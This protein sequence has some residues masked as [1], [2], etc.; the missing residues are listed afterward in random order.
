MATFNA[1]EEMKRAF[2][3]RNNFHK[4]YQE[5]F[6]K[7]WKGAY[8]YTRHPDDW[9]METP[10]KIGGEI[11]DCYFEGDGMFTIYME[12]WCEKNKEYRLAQ[13]L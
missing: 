13:I 2:E 5:E 10:R 1:N 7:E 8:V 9:G 11:V 12:Y 6:L 4:T 3:A